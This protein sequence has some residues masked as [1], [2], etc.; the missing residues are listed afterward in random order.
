[1]KIGCTEAGGIDMTSTRTVQATIV[2]IALMA[3]VTSAGA[4]GARGVREVTLP[5]GTVLPLTLDTPVASATSRVE[6][7]VRAHLR[8]ALIVD[9]REVLPAG[10]L[11]TGF[12]SEA[13]RSARVKG[14]ARVAFRFTSLSHDSERYRLQT[15]RVVREAAGTKAR[16]AKSIAIPAG[17]GAVI[18]AIAGG[19]KGAAIG[20]AVGGGAGTGVVLSTRG[21]EVRVGRGAAIGV[22]LLQPVTVS[23]R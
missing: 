20:G 8:R 22:R 2:A 6:D 14:R 23:V 16:D 3:T 19:K 1:M 9:G 18:G 10:T 4:A 11:V 12:V 7:P 15:S 13:T 21:K 17:A 5:A